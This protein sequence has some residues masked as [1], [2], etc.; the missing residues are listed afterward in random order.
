MLAPMRKGMAM[1]LARSILFGTAAIFAGS[2][3]PAKAQ[4]PTIVA[5]ISIPQTPLSL[6]AES[7]VRSKEPDFLFNHSVRT[8]VF[9]A[10][11][12][13]ARGIAFDP[14]AAFVAALFHDIGLV[15]AI[16]SPDVSFEI[17]GANKAEE[18]V[19]TNGGSPDEARIVWNAIVMHDMGGA[20]QR[21]QSGREALLLGAGA[22]SDVDG[23]D[24]KTIPAATVAEVLAAFPRLGFKKRFTAAAIDHCRRKPTSQIGWLDPLC[25]K[26]VPDADR[27]DVEKEIESAPF[28]E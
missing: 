1:K 3:A 2:F 21:H 12:L 13:K 6:K 28:P 18:F 7:F 10:L 23:V 9:G 20:Y 17:D 22:G 19:R 15:P 8:Y 11:R 25:R 26:I 5:G 27:G 14:E 24:P 4:M 16:A